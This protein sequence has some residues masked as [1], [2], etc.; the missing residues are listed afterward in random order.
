MTALLCSRKAG[1]AVGVGGIPYAVYQRSA[2]AR[3]LLFQRTDRC[4]RERKN[5]DLDG[6]SWTKF[7][8]IYTYNYD[9]DLTV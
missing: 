5:P 1:S 7:I 9:L 8:G 6:L 3:S 4:L 2:L